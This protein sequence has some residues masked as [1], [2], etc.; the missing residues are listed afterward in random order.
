MAVQG[1]NFCRRLDRNIKII[2]RWHGDGEN[3][4]IVEKEFLLTIDELFAR[5]LVDISKKGE[6][7]RVKEFL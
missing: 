5:R 1:W 7:V 3:V 6:F 4:L 2:Y